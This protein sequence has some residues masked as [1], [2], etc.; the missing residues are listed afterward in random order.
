MWRNERA[1]P[2]M[3]ENNMFK[4]PNTPHS[5]KGEKGEFGL[6]GVIMRQGCAIP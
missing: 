5:R 2:V 6:P 1:R 3:L 4:G